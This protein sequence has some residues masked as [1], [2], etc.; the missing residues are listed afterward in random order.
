MMGSG[1]TTVG[2]TLADVSQ[3]EFFDTDLL[4]QQKL[5]RPISQIFQLYGEDAFRCHETC[6]LRGLEP[7]PYIL[8]TGGGIV[9]RP[10]NWPELRRLGVVVYLKATPDVLIERL[11]R[12]R[13]KR[14]LLDVEGWQDRL[15][16]L[17]AQRTPLYE[18]ADLTVE[19]EKAELD[20][21]TEAVLRA[22]EGAGHA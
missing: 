19:L 4:L 13:K 22:I 15:R 17:L 10:E 6:L 8:A 9:I 11:E 3:R 21:A 18:Q 16:A 12:S 20:D 2:R 7:G 1:K 5:G 14:P